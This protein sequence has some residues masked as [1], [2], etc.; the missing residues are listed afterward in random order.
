MSL[1]TTEPN[2]PTATATGGATATT[3]TRHAPASRLGT[4]TLA[5]IVTGLARAEE[6]W[7]PHA[8]HDPVERA[9]IRLLA[10][11]AYEVWLLGWTPGQSAGLHDHGGANAAFVVVDGELTETVASEPGNR[12]SRALRQRTIEAGRLALVRAGEIHDLTNHANRPATSI[13][14]YSKPLRSMGFYEKSATGERGHRVRTIW[15]DEQDPVLHGIPAD[16][17]T[18]G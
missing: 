7:Q 4:S 9:C 17:R 11:P 16:T 10:T 2:R 8:R 12:S 13:H 14:V 1:V 15:V 18:L 3:T 6:L 5:D